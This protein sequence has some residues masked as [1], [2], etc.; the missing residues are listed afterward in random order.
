MDKIYWKCDICGNVFDKWVQEH[1][2]PLDK[3]DREAV[4][5]KVGL[6]TCR[7]YEDTCGTC[8]PIIVGLIEGA[9]NERKVSNGDI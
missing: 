7:Y 5:W 6:E 9:I 4:L 3:P 2:T 8:R 1:G